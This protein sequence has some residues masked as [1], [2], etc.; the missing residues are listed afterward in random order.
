MTDTRPD[1]LL[2]LVAALLLGLAGGCDS[3]NPAAPAGISPSADVGAA[4]AGDDAAASPDGA[5]PAFAPAYPGARVLSRV[6]ATG[7]DGAGTVLV[8]E[9]DAPF[10]D[11]VRFYDRAATRTGAAA[12]MRMDKEG[13]SVRMFRGQGAADGGAMLVIE[14]G[15]GSRGTRIILTTGESHLGIDMPGLAVAGPPPPPPPPAPAG[16]RVAERKALTSDVR[17]Q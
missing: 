1:R 17:L 14:Q 8:M 9:A 15:D 16:D 3:A 7:A 13:K 6:S 2:P 5:L 10:A 11:V 12:A 4:A